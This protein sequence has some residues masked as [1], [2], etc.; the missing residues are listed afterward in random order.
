MAAGDAVGWQR[1][2]FRVTRLSQIGYV[3]H[4]SEEP[5]I[6]PDAGNTD[7]SRGE[8]RKSSKQ[9]ISF[10]SRMDRAEAVTYFE[11]IV[12]GLKSG[13]VEFRQG[14]DELVLSV[15]EDVEVAV[16]AS[17][18][19]EKEKVSFSLEWREG[20]APGLTIVPS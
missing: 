12:A 7:E 16:K 20:A 3:P 17:K 6:S 14:E 10:D 9:K 2:A 13:R 11:A 15:G 4:M 19:G 8:S 5:E 1:L 18:K